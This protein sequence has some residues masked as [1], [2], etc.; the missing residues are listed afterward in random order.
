[1][2]DVRGRAN[3]SLIVNYTPG[4]LAEAGGTEPLQP[5]EKPDPTTYAINHNLTSLIARARSYVS[6]PFPP[7]ETDYV[8]TAGEHYDAL[9]GHMVY[10]KTW[11]QSKF[12]SNTA[13][14]SLI[15]EP[16]SHLKSCMSFYSLPK[17]LNITS[18][19]PIKTFLRD[20]WK[21]Q[22]LSEAFFTFC[23]EAA[24]AYIKG[25]DEDFTL[26]LLL[27]HLDES[28]VLLRRLMRWGIQDVLYDI[29]PKNVRK[30]TYKSYTPTAEELANLRRWKAVDYRL[31][32]MF[33]RSL[34]RK[35]EAEGPDFYQELQYY[36]EL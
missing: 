5:R 2:Y 25:L 31:Y 11:L 27:E 8:H 15:R 16:F 12:P 28:L 23:N 9:F 19:N 35:I 3:Q 6:W 26:V 20:P 14:I 17:L 21:Y 34:W 32:D 4:N 10:N 33:N 7:A 24:E 30:Y 29:I 1:M 13:Y 18:T 22:N 36:R